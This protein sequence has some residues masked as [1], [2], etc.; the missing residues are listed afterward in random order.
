MPYAQGQVTARDLRTEVYWAS[1]RARRITRALLVRLIRFARK[2]PRERCQAIAR[3]RLRRANPFRSLLISDGSEVRFGNDRTAYI[4][5]LWGSGRMYVLDLLRQKIGERAAYLR[6]AIGL[7]QG[8]TS[9]IYVGHSTIKYVSR[10]H[11]PPATTSRLLESVRLGFA[12][13]IFI[14]RHPLDS[15]LTNWFFSRNRIR[16]NTVAYISDAYKST[17]DICAVLQRNFSELKAL[18]EG[19]PDYMAVL[20]NG[21]RFM[22]LPEFVEETTLFAQCSTLALRLEDFSID[23]AKEFSKI[24]GVMSA[25]VD[26]SR[27]RLEPPRTRPYRYLEVKEKVPQFRKLIDGLDAETKRRIEQIGYTV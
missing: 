23:P 19:D 1:R 24:V 25:D 4:I 9:M 18:A 5:G 6:E 20:P 26:V 10:G 21:P 15:L 14:Y 11:Q 12:D 13:L 2:S 22:S 8:P 7:H 27:L 16:D 17:D 3:Y